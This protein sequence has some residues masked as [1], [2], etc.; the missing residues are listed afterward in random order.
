MVHSWFPLLHTCFA[1]ALG[2]DFVSPLSGQ[3]G[4]PGGTNGMQDPPCCTSMPAPTHW[5]SLVA[6]FSQAFCDG[7]VLQVSHRLSLHA[8]ST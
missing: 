2:T 8:A 5:Q 6:M 4:S 7:A 3:K 1:L